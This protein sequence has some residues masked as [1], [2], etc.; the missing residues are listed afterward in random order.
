MRLFIAIDLP[1]MVKEQ[2]APLCC[3]LPGA[4]WIPPEQMHL[5]LH[6]IG[7]VEGGVFL[8]IQEGL[9]SVY[10]ERLYLQLDGVG[11]FPPRGKPRVVWAGLKKSELLLQLYN[12][13]EAKLVALGLK[14]EKRKFSPHITLA[15]LK[16]TPPV[17]VGRFL[18]NHGLFLSQSFAVE[19]F[20]LYSS[21]LGRKG[22]IH[23]KETTY[24]L[25]ETG[26]V[27]TSR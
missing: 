26:V 5:T 25:N 24:F 4:R 18:E 14:L 2:L 23:R 3:G 9:A 20:H 19:R 27:S 17:K 13:I 15:R 22:A 12:R 8:D 21:I 11:F 16:N 6:F 1:D 10:A 7:E